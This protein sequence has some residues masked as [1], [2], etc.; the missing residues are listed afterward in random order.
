LRARSG[1]FLFITGRLDR[2]EMNAEIIKTVFD[3]GFG[4]LALAGVS[5][6]FIAGSAPA[7]LISA[8]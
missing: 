1:T 3:F 4:W 6:L 2:N 8:T 7:L 5:D